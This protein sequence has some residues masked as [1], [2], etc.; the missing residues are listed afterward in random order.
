MVWHLTH[1]PAGEGATR[2]FA[3]YGRTVDAARQK[4]ADALAV[5]LPTIQQTPGDIPS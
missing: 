5:P 3:V 2:D 4:L 1:T